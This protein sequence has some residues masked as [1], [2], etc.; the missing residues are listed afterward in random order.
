MNLRNS[1]LPRLRLACVVGRSM[2]PAF[3]PGDLVVGVWPS[4][5]KCGDV[6]LFREPTHELYVIHRVIDITADHVLT[7]GDSNPRSLTEM[8]EVDRINAKVILGIPSLGSAILWLRGKI[9][10]IHEYPEQ[11]MPSVR[12]DQRT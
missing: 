11:A 4:S 6:V 9:G 3:D 7:R 10:A 8:I 5:L 2:H 1:E 12:R